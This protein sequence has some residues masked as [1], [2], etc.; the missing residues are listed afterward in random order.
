MPTILENDKAVEE[1]IEIEEAD[2]D[3]SDSD[4]C[5]LS[6]EPL[7]LGKV[8]ENATN[9]TSPH[10]IIDSDD[11]TGPAP[12]NNDPS[13]EHT[14]AIL[15]QDLRRQY[16]TKSIVYSGGD[17]H[18]ESSKL[19]TANSKVPSM[20]VEA[21][22]SLSKQLAKTNQTDDLELQSVTKYIVYSGTADSKF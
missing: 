3:I 20:S 15:I 11:E 6:N 4:S 7:E 14:P 18:K 21:H 22:S 2:I 8:T 9:A 1:I 19:Q 16:V 13:K 17:V 5:I 10:L 12:I